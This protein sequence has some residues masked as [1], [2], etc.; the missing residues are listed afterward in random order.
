MFCCTS[1][2]LVHVFP[3]FET[4]DQPHSGESYLNPT[5]GKRC[6]GWIRKLCF[7]TSSI[8]PKTSETFCAK[9]LVMFWMFWFY[10]LLGLLIDSWKQAQSESDPSTVQ[11]EK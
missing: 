4:M 6:D 11:H 10:N 1:K 2:D 9:S 7:G 3:D 5:K 8:N